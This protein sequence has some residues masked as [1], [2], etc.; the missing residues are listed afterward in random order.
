MICLGRFENAI[1]LILNTAPDEV[2]LSAGIIPGEE[3]DKSQKIEENCPPLSLTVSLDSKKIVKLAQHEAIKIGCWVIISYRVKKSTKSYLG[4]IINNNGDGTF[5]A[6]FLRRLKE[7]TNTFTWPDNDDEDC[8]PE[9][10]IIRIL[11]EPNINRRGQLL[12]NDIQD[13]ALE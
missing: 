9:D 4:Q 11:N 13:I 2:K 3:S 1:L 7:T 5:V 12:F 10:S 8:I 6:K